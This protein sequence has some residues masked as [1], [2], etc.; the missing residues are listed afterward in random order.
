MALSFSCDISVNGHFGGRYIHFWDLHM[1]E[2][3]C[4]FENALNN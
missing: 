1:L 3:I 4:V 2:N